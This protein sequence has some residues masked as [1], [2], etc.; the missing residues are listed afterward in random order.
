MNEDQRKMYQAEQ[1]Q[2]RQDL[3]REAL[4]ASAQ[5]DV[6]L[7]S[8][9]EVILEVEAAQDE[10]DAKQKELDTLVAVSQQDILPSI[11]LKYVSLSVGRK[12]S[13]SVQREFNF[14]MVQAFCGRPPLQI[15]F[16]YFDF[17]FW[18]ACWF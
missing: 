7:V 12:R 18:V 10:L 6:F 13:H 14:R 2:G 9:L 17:F 1:A 3:W 5:G 16:N 4:E 11:Y 8:L 15:L